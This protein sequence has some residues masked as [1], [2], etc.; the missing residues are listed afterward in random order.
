MHV[1]EHRAAERDVMQVGK[2]N[3]CAGTQHHLYSHLSCAA[4]CSLPAVAPAHLAAFPAECL[5]LRPL[6]NEHSSLPN[7]PSFTATLTL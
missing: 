3:S 6:N 5:L 4:T 1:R 2:S 7:S